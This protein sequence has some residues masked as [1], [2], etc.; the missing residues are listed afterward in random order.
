MA[1]TPFIFKLAPILASRSMKLPLPE[2]SKSGLKDLDT[3]EQVNEEHHLVI[4]GYGIVG[5]NV[6]RTARFAQLKYNIIEMNPQTVREEQ[7]K[8]TPIFYGDATQSV[9]L[10]YAG[11]QQAMTLVIAIADSAAM[12]RIITN[13]RRLNPNLHII[14]RTR[15]VNDIQ[16]YHKLGADEVIPEEFKTSVEIFA[17]TLAKFLVPRDEI[18]KMIKKVREDD[19]MLR[20]LSLGYKG[21]Y[22]NLKVNLPKFDISTW[23]VA[24]NSKICGMK[25][26]ELEQIYDNL[27]IIAISRDEQ[28]IS[29]PMDATIQE[30][31]ILFILG[32]T[33]NL[34]SMMQLCH[35]ENVE[36]DNTCK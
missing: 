6:S 19:G 23:K 7:Q 17:R 18:E 34:S 22:S 27:T 29:N 10:K 4:I 30:N 8:D 2:R 36:N 25:V 20:S 33:K 15:F 12:K 16:T 13:A 9:I 11:I 5:R 31:D 35:N 24:P 26:S 21:N 28:I 1:L 3:A 32:A 14:V